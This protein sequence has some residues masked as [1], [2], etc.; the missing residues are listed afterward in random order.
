[1]SALSLIRDGAERIV[2]KS[3]KAL[4]L[5]A[6]PRVSDIE[7]QLRKILPE[8]IVEAEFTGEPGPLKKEAVLAAVAY[9]YDT[10][11]RPRPMPYGLGIILHPLFRWLVLRAADKAIDVSVTVMN[12]YG[13]MPGKAA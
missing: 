1:M 5:I 12:K 10:I 11:I 13:I 8:F 4:A 9:W 2:T 7:A 3:Q 6:L